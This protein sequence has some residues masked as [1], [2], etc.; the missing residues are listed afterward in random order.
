LH[1]SEE[2]EAFADLDYYKLKVGCKLTNK[3]L[4]TAG[5]TA[6]YAEIG[7]VWADD[8]KR[9]EFEAARLGITPEELFQRLAMEGVE[10]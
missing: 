4:S 7:R 5:Q 1:K 9:L 10:E 6:L 8:E 2:G 3:S